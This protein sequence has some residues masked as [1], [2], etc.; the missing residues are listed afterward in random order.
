MSGYL[1]DVRY[2]S[3]PMTEAYPMSAGILV[4]LHQYQEAGVVHAG[5]GLTLQSSIPVSFRT[6]SINPFCRKVISLVFLLNW[7]STPR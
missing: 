1:F 6:L 2:I 3:I 5:V 4:Y 7:T